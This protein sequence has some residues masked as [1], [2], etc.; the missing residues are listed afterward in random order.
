MTPI[1]PIST[2]IRGNW[3]VAIY[4]IVEVDFGTKGGSRCRRLSYMAADMG[5]NCGEATPSPRTRTV[6]DVR[7]I[8]IHIDRAD[9]R[10]IRGNHT[11]IIQ[12]HI[13]AHP[14]VEGWGG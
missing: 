5:L 11:R 1:E 10:T 3:W 8:D 12:Q 14:D 7:A 9:V 6:E 2:C 13:D 4:P